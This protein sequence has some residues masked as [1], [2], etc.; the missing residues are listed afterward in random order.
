LK[1][2][3]KALRAAQ[4]KAGKNAGD[5]EEGDEDGGDEANTVGREDVANLRAKAI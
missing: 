1:E 3:K 5:E 4:K 2:Q